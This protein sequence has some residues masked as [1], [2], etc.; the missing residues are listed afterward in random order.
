MINHNPDLEISLP[1]GCGVATYPAGA[2]YGPRR[3]R[4]YELVWMIEGDAEYHCGGVVTPAPAGS[5]LLCRPAAE[6]FFQW[7][8]RRR[9]RHGFCHFEI[10]ALP[11]E[12]PSPEQ[13]P[14]VRRLPDEDILRPLF[15]HLLT[16]QGRQSD[17]QTRLTL[18]ALLSLFVSG[19]LDTA[20]VER[21]DWPEAVERAC[22]FLFRT[23]EADPAAPLSLAA[24]AD[25][26]S[27]TPEHLCRLFKVSVGHSPAQT[28]R[29]ARLDYAATLLARSNF[30]VGEIS[31]LCG[32][33]SPFHFSRLFRSA[34]GQ[35]PTGA[36]R[37]AGTAAI[38]RLLPRA[39]QFQAYSR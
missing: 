27:V 5:I 38:P 10:A 20:S 29:L 26:A 28:V 23:L 13:W 18:A 39:Y 22:D 35:T 16:W 32:F 25:A 3:L 24:L 17:R 4:D 34:F 14:V 6:D 15:R 9:T 33:A 8:R 37:T 7:D 36:R 31:A 1:T 30:S 2:S 12:W 11:I 21:D 19:D